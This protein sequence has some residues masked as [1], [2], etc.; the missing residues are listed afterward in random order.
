MSSEPPFDNDPDTEPFRQI[1]GHE[2]KRAAVALAVLAVAALA[3][4]AVMLYAFG[5]SGDGNSGPTDNAGPSGPPVT[6]TGGPAQPS[7]SSSTRSRPKPTPT[8]TASTS[9]SS[10]GGHVSCPTSAPCT[11]PDDVGN[12]VQALNDYRT[13]HGQKAVTGSVT[14]AAKTCALSNGNDCP[15]SFFWEPVGRDGTEVIHKIAASSKGTSWLLDKSMTAVAVG[16]A[17][18]P[19]SHSFECAMVAKH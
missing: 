6:V 3:L 12:A 10:H 16:W 18:I 11:V 14:S 7:Q 1:G 2:R 15:S 17:Y 4:L 5:S 19:G 13:S 9:T 8:K